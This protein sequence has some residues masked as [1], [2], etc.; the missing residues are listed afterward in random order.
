RVENLE[1]DKIAQALEIT[2]LKQRVKRLEKRNKVKVSGLKR[3]KK[4]V[5]AEVVTT[6]DVEV[7]KNADVQGRQKES[8]AQAYHI[9][10]EHVDKVLSMHDDEPEP[11]ELKEVIKVVTTAKVMI[12][13]VTAVAT[14]ITVA[15]RMSYDDIQPIF[16]KYFNSNVAFLEK[17]EKELEEE[18]SRALKRKPESSEEKA[19]KK[20]KLDEEVE[21]LKKHLQIVSNNEDD[22]DTEATPLALKLFLSFLSLLRNFDREDLEMLWK[23]VQERF[24]SLKP[25][26]F[27]DDF[28]LATLKAMF[29]KPDVQ[30]Q[31]WK[32]QRGIHGLVK[33]KSWKLLESCGFHI[34]T[35]TNTQMILLVERRYPLI[36]FILDPMLNNV[37]LEVEEESEV[38][39][40]PLRFVRLQEYTLR[41]YYYWL[42]TYC[43]WYKLKLLDNVADSRLRLLEQSAAVDDKMKKYN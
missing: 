31:V 7:E 5:A 23:I 18:A 36:R 26:N 32:N 34:I 25:N 4:G 33:V 17:S 9:D 27:S 2:K 28:L 3:L 1:Q 39:L 37:R 19:V 11:A 42:K 24:A 29:E 15:P 35:F 16:E 13:V 6:K 43:C 20:Q 38:S 14:T 12:E 30:D 8:Q 22:V 41:D 40:E 10:L 21:E